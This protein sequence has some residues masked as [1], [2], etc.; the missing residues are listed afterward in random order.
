MGMTVPALVYAAS[1]IVTGLLNIRLIR[2]VTS[3]PVVSESAPRDRIA[4]VR[5]RGP[6]VVLGA[7]CAV[8]I[9]LWDARWSQTGLITIPI[10]MLIVMLSP[11]D[12]LVAAK[13][14]AGC[15]SKQ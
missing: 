15:I 3:P 4:Y 10:W 5:A 9:A 1:L 6:A 7:I 11:L 12:A 14:A 8:L 2:I 13:A